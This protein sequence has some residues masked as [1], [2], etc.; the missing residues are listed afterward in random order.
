VVFCIVANFLSILAP[1]AIAPG[2]L[3]PVK[4]K[5]MMILIHLAFF[6]LL[7]VA[8]STTL[9]PLGIEFFLSWSGVST[10][11]P[12][13]LLLSILELVGIAF[14]YPAVLDVQGRMLQ[15]REHQILEVVT[16]KVE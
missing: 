14:V 12:A 6:F 2:S 7:P 8:L 5:G 10:Y 16:T 4:P 11:F 3:K 1:M 9:F 15:N 13:Y